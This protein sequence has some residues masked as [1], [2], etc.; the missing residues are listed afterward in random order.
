MQRATS[1]AKRFDE[2]SDT[3]N[4]NSCNDMSEPRSRVTENADKFV[5]R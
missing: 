1:R 4:D 5:S 3:E 2:E